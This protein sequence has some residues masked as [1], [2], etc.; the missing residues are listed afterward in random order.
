MLII[1]IIIIM[2]VNMMMIMI[3]NMVMLMNLT[4]VSYHH[5]EAPRAGRD[6]VGGC[7]IMWC[8]YGIGRENW[9]RVV[10]RFVDRDASP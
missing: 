2:I 7:S 6:S 5:H 1:L 10:L 3:K 8:P 9:D 4:M